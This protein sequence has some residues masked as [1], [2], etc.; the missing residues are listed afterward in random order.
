[1]TGHIDLNITRSGNSEKTGEKIRISGHEL[2]WKHGST[3]K[4]PCSG[5][6]FGTLRFIASREGFDIVC[7]VDVRGKKILP[8]RAEI[9]ETGLER[10]GLLD[11]E[12]V[13]DC[14]DMPQ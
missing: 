11:V 12:I 9:R 7:V 2:K 6:V 5:E 8:R 10:F 13:E 4:D 14:L 3:I 1:M